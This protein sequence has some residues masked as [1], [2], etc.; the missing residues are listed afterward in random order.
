M[1]KIDRACYTSRAPSRMRARFAVVTTLAGACLAA[2]SYPEY[3]TYKSPNGD[4]TCR[5]P[6]TWSVKVDS[7]GTRFFHANFIGPFDPDFYLGAPSL[8]VRWHSH[9]QARKLADGLLEVYSGV[10]DYIA[11]MLNS[12]YNSMDLGLFKD[13]GEEARRAG[14]EAYPGHILLK[15]GVEELMLPGA[16]RKGKHFVVRSPVP[17]PKKT[18]WGVSFNKEGDAAIVRQHAY[19]LLPMDGGFYVLVYPATQ[20]GYEKHERQFLELVNS[21]TPLKHGPG[22]APLPA[23]KP[24]TARQ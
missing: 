4:F 18:M 3:H 6:Y 21:F 1:D 24:A 14:Q 7:D 11:Q 16:G 22:G 19:V 20:D 9:Y 23:P 17:V 12:V 5:V 2:C 10:D 8:S 13:K 15:D